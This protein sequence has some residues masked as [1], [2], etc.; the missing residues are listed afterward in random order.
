MTK[1]AQNLA[2]GNQLVIDGKEYRVLEVVKINEDEV[3]VDVRKMHSQG[4]GYTEFVF[5]N[6]AQIYLTYPT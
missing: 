3:R 1:Q 4:Y 5:K 2:Q 6:D